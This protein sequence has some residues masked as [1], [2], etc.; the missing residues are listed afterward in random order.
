M[1]RNGR[2][3]GMIAITCCL[4][5]A[6]IA[7]T[8]LA[9]DVRVGQAGK[10]FTP[11]EVAI[12]PGDQVIFV[13][14]DTIDHNVFSRSEGAKFNLKL[15]KPGEEK[16]RTFETPGRHTVRCAIHPKMRLTVVVE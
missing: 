4:A 15:Q 6:A 12:S 13:N 9:D 16:A 10:A 11:G 7:P 3:L 2:R 5:A 14:D 1:I 8:A